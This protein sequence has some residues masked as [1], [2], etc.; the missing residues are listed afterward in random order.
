MHPLHSAARPGRRPALRLLAAFVAVPA[1]LFGLPAAAGATWVVGDNLIQNLPLRVLV[2][3]DLRR[4]H[5]PLWNPYIWS[6]V[7]LLAGFNAGAAYPGTWLF[8]VLPS[9][10]AWVVNQVVVEVVAAAGVLVLLRLFGRSWA[11]AGLGAAAFTYGGFMAAQSVHLDLVQAAAWL[12]WAF[13]ALDRL[14]RRPEGR[15][16]APW[17]ALLGAALGLMGLS[18]AVEPAL[19]GGV[20]LVVFAAWLWLRTPARR[21]S[22]ALGGLLGTALGVLVAGAQLLPGALYQGQS[23]RGMHSYTYFVSGSMAKSLT[24]LGFD[25]LL[26]GGGHGF[27]ATY[28]GSY[29]LPE[30]SSYI[31]ILPVMA[32]VGLLARRHRRHPEAA[33]WWIWYAIA[34]IGMVFAWGGYTPLGHFLYSVPFYNRQRLLNRNLLEVDLA[35]AVLFAAWVDHMFLSPAGDSGR[36]PHD[37]GTRWWLRIPGPAGWRSD[38]VLALLPPAAV[39]ALQV[40]MLGGGAWLPHLMNV[41]LPVT[42]ASLRP[43][44]LFLTVPSIVALGAAW[45]VVRRHRLARTAAWLTALVVVDLAVFNVVAQVTPD[46]DAATNGHAAWANELAATVAADGGHRM[47]IFDPERIDAIDTNRLGEP[48]LNVLRDVDSIQG[49]GAVVDA[50]YETAT[51][52]HQQLSMVPFD[53]VD[54]TY[55]RL[56]LGVLASVPEYFVHMVSAPPGFSGDTANGVVAL[57]PVAPN[58]HAPPDR[59]PAPPT[60]PAD[61]TT[62]APPTA[63]VTLVPGRSRTQFFG[64]VLWVR[65]V[66]VPLPAPAPGPA[67]AVRVGLV[68][69]DGRRTTWVGA[70]SA[71]GA[72]ITVT[73][74]HPRPASGIV[75]V[76]VPGPGVAPTEV[77]AAVVR[78]AGQGTYR[79]DGS[80]RDIVAPPQWHFARTIGP[81]PVFEAAAP[82][83]EAWVQGAPGGRARVVSSTPW[84]DETIRVTSPRPALLVRPEQYATGWQ[85]TVTPAGSAGRSTGPGG[86]AASVAQDGLVQS[87]HVPAGTSL[88]RFTYLPHRVVEGLV[89]SAVGFVAVGLV[90]LWPWARRRRA[91]RRPTGPAQEPAGASGP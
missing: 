64:T 5:L 31:G 67:G 10:L 71:G 17:V 35:L 26:L 79:V 86:Q 88:V 6:G 1:A 58:L 42:R 47:G 34:G 49:Y 28:F 54:G 68:S 39:V 40:A 78:T 91:R 32:L 89:T 46:P 61:F 57:P 56:D 90:A 84:G 25:P 73:V 69:A 72:R 15:P 21:A 60:P 13:V 23:Q 4:W 66:S 3:I 41:P 83:G 16:G 75:L 8:A 45:L 53:L 29:N 59:A 51:G 48:D 30:V 11:A 22:I 80:L 7:P 12:P 50:T 36:T 19:D 76:L 24:L 43:L 74:R 9:A 82:S 33:Q 27:P 85:A 77:G 62:V 14:A 44:A 87:V 63:T 81:F 55:A 70:G 2:G 37:G 18:G 65:S 20:V 38:V 52:T